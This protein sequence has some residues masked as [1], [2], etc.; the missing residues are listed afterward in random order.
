MGPYTYTPSSTYYEPS[1]NGTLSKDG[2]PVTLQVTEPLLQKFLD[3]MALLE[4]DL[5]RRWG[6]LENEWAHL[7]SGRVIKSCHE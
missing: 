7:P 4:A 3:T 5:V 6:S 2:L 1:A